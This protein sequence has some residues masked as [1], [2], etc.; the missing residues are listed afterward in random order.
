MVK[1]S[2]NHLYFIKSEGQVA[3]TRTPLLPATRS[4][5]TY[6]WHRLNPIALKGAVML[7]GG[8]ARVFFGSVIDGRDHAS[9]GDCP[10]G[11][12][13]GKAGIAT[14]G[15]IAN[16]GGSLIGGTGFPAGDT[17]YPNFSAMY[18]TVGIR[19]DILKDPSFPVDFQNTMPNFASLPADSFP[20]IRYNGDLSAWG[21]WYSGRGVL[22]VTGRLI[23]LYDFQTDGIILAGQFSLRPKTQ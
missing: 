17:G 21:N 1:D 4:V 7:T 20:I 19:W 8:L 11:S 13:P 22:I 10:G 2:L 18:D 23:V 12:T 15:T 3:D 5:G 6:A 16:S 9:T 14:A